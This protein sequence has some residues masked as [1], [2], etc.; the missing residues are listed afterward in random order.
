MRA[1]GLDAYASNGR[2]PNYTLE[3]SFEATK[4]PA[5]AQL[6]RML[7]ERMEK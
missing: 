1:D 5:I 3:K 6:K 7:K 2:Q 4:N